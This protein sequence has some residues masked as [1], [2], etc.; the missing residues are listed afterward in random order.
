MQDVVEEYKTFEGH[1]ED[2]ICMATY[3]DRCV[4][5]TGDYEG[6]ITVWNLNAGE[7]RFSLF[8]RSDRCARRPPSRFCCGSFVPLLPP[9]PCRIR[10]LLPC[11]LCVD[12]ALMP[13]QQRAR[14]F[15]P[16]PHATQTCVAFSC[17]FLHVS[18]LSFS[19]HVHQVRERRRGALLAASGEQERGV[20]AAARAR[21]LRR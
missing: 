7:K 4:L 15:V 19:S 18:R 3:A 2:I 9:P 21:V 14:A 16:S 1:K 10:T 6:R 13:A 11:A 8:H 12:R 17:L 20:W 5:A